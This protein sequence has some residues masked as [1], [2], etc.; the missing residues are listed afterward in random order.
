MKKIHFGL[1]AAIMMVS[2]F[3]SAQAVDQGKKFLYYQRL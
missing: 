3:V 2:N 1:L